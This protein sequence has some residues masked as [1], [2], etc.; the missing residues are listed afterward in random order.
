MS[1]EFGLSVVVTGASTG[2]GE[3]TALHLDKCGWRVFAGVRRA[4]DGERLQAQGSPRL[5]ALTL[6][7]R[8]ADSIAAA[9]AEVSGQTGRWGLDGLVNNAGISG[10]DPLEFTPLDSLRAMLEVNLVGLVA[11]TQAFL[12]MLRQSQGRIVCIGSIG[13][14]TPVPFTAAYA[15]SKA[16][17]GAICDCL[18]LELRPWHIRVAL[19]EPGAVATPIWEKGLSEFA[20]KAAA[21][22]A[23]AMELYGEAIGPMRKASEKAARSGIA[24]SRV[25]RAVE[26]ALTASRPR[27]RY[28]VGV[29]A[30]MQAA[31]RRLPDRAR[32]RLI[33]RVIG[34]P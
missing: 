9:T 17:V 22:P 24:P 31:V 4:E 25:A 33:G 28:L 14:R 19:V 3:A 34:L 6:D 23:S 32:D 7:V 29:D 1:Q 16:A 8:D 13:G 30:K 10:G 11:T 26:H 18:R 12:P 15:A 27:T 21:Y 5:T 2:I 20:A